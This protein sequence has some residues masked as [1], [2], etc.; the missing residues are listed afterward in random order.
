MS[1]DGMDSL[2]ATSPEQRLQDEDRAYFRHTA[3]MSDEDLAKTFEPYEE[4]KKLLAQQ[5]EQAVAL[6]HQPKSKYT[7]GAAAALG[8]LADIGN[9]ITSL[10]QEAKLRSQQ[11]DALDS[12]RDATGKQTGDYAKARVK[13]FDA[14]DAQ[15]AQQLRIAEELRGRGSMGQMGQQP[16]PVTQPPAYEMFVPR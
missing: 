6:R 10:F 9:H 15:Q 8:G 1:G 4:R 5:L 16:G 13:E 11:K 12:Q 7:G 2:G 3:G 14:S